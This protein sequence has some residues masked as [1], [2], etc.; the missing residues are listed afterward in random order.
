MRKVLVA[1]AATLVYLLLSRNAW[2]A[3][4]L[5]ATPTTMAIQLPTVHAGEQVVVVARLTTDTGAPLGHEWVIFRVGADDDGQTQTDSDGRATWRIQRKL[6]IGTSQIVA[7]FN[8]SQNLGPSHA[9][10]QISI[11]ATTLSIRVEPSLGAGSRRADAIARLTDAVG[12][13][14]P[15]ARIVFSVD[16]A[17]Q[18]ELL[19]DAS[20]TARWP[21]WPALVAGTH[22]IEAGFNG[23]PALLAARGSTQFVVAKVLLT[24][25]MGTPL[26]AIEKDP[27]V[28]ARLT[29]ATG[30]PVANA[31]IVFSVDGTVAGEARTDT[32]GQASRR[33]QRALSPGKHTVV[34]AFIGRSD[35]QSARASLEITM[36]ATQLML[37]FDRARSQGGMQAP[38]VARLTDASG[39]PVA[40]ARVVF[41]VGGEQDGEAFTGDDG[42]AVWRIKHDLPAGTHMVEGVFAGLPQ[43]LGARASTSVVVAPTALELRTVLASSRVGQ[44]ATVIARLVDAAGIPAANA[45]IVLFVNGV[46]HGEIRTDANGV[47]SRRLNHTLST[48]TYTVEGVF[49]GLPGLLPSRTS[50]PLLVEPAMVEVQ[51]VPALAGV[52]FALDGRTFV[53]GDDGIARI[54]VDQVGDYK[55]EALPWD[56]DKAGVHAEFDR[57]SDAIFVATRTVKIPGRVRLMAG[58]NVSYLISQ[59]FVD[60][61]GRP[62]DPKRISSFALTSSYGTRHFFNNVQPR[63]LQGIHVVRLKEGLAES[64]V[65]YALESVII[66][67]AD[68]VNQSQQRFAAHQGQQWQLQLQLYSVHFVARDALFGFPIGSAIHL[69]YPDGQS[70]TRP[71]GRDGDVRIDALAR[72]AYTIRIDAPGIAGPTPAALSHDQE[73]VLLV[74]SYLDLAVVGVFLLAIALG[75]LFVGQPRLRMFARDPLAPLRRGMDGQRPVLVWLQA[76]PLQLHHS[77]RRRGA[78]LR[79]VLAQIRNRGTL[80]LGAGALD[81]VEIAI[82]AER[83]GALPSAARAR[84]WRWLLDPA[85]IFACMLVALG[86]V[87]GALARSAAPSTPAI[88]AQPARTAGLA[89]THHVDTQPIA[90]PTLAPTLAP[91]APAATP[92]SAVATAAA[93]T[94]Q[95]PLAF[96]RNLNRES[97]GSEVVQL[98]Q[99]LRELGY[100]DYPDNTGYFGAETARALAE[101]QAQRGLAVT[102]IADRGTVAALNRCGEDCVAHTSRGDQ[103]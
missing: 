72:G 51:T 90:A 6:P 29:D 100:F 4:S 21:I 9:D 97:N 35:L 76:I 3:E 59:E 83:Q 68:V 41:L 58:F 20:G 60:P 25:Q 43:L 40:K 7:V 22:T 62:I 17:R 91:T 81:G 23:L 93:L 69:T 85:L 2:A 12:A 19:T 53:S 57:W 34:A 66:D 61:A 39:A 74:L 44:P 37:Q 33:I 75:L 87:G 50:M 63:W 5:A 24:I 13:P 70:R 48:G 54:T 31:R 78:A 103:H 14:V 89:P 64:P 52:R 26:S 84:L 98:Q 11:G 65:T 36:A 80:V 96:T 73:V 82:T 77:V 18:V 8:G 92:T 46:R 28:A 27:S 71:L 94:S 56:G 99:R 86:A 15:A 101:F 95:T 30:A 32:S 67:G 42:T 79:L 45:H 88:V 49:E 10:G 16:G 38:I 47:A 1:L 102:G 55:L